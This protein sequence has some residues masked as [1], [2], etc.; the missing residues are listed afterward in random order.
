MSSETFTAAVV[1]AASVCF[2]LQGS[3]DKLE[4]LAREAAD[5][6]A[7]LAVFPEAFLSG[8]PSSLDWGGQSAAIREDVAAADYERYW[9]SA[10]ELDEQGHVQLS[11][12]ARE[13]GLHLVVGVIEREQASLYC[14]SAMFG[15][16][17]RFLGKHRKIMPTV[18]ERLVW[19]QGDGSTLAAVETPL[20][21]LGSVICWENY[22]PL[23]RMHMYQQGIELYC[24]PTADDEPG[25]TATMQHI[26]MEGRCYVL[27]ANQFTR[28][29]DFPADYG[30]F[31]SDD[32]DF[33]VS[34][35]GSCIVDPFGK[36]LAGPDHEGETILY[37]DI[38]LSAIV[39][40]KFYS[41]VV[42]HYARPDLLSMTVNLAEMRNVRTADEPG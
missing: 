8:Y 34:H 23:L 38:D 37:A 20:G 36:V 41:D 32:T 10:I 16:D 2:D 33:I 25:W 39:R 12:I 18:A 28:R 11:R 35:G 19:T 5:N 7:R 1:Q 29:G 31:P 42:G 14:T 22:M 17:G 6:G 27:S 24:A 3:L 9:R 4:S 26:A 21:K 30:N 13:T 40:G 15:A